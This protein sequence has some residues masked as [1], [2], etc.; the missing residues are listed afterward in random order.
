M[1]KIIVS[2][3]ITTTQTRRMKRKRRVNVVGIAFNFDAVSPN[4]WHSFNLLRAL[5]VHQN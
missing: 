1:I 5:N 4:G 3:T 2:T